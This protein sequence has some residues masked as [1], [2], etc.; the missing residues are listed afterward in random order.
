M[1]KKFSIFLSALFCSFLGGML[2]ISTILPDQDFSELENRYLQKA[3]VFSWKNIQDGKFMSDAEDYVRDHL[4]GRDLWVSM[5]SWCERLTG[6]QE[7]NGV[8]YS[9]GTLIN[10]YTAPDAAQL[11]QNVAHIN[12][13]VAVVIVKLK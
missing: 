10:D 5:K 4:L 3:P 6:K 8:Y 9:D 7:N 12:T 11:Q 2:I 1:S 13:L